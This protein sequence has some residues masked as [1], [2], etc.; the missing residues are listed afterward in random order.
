MKLIILDRDGVINEDSDEYI[1]SVDEWVPI[2]GSLEAIAR[3]NQAGYHV[4]VATN[5]S[6]IARGYYDL[7][8]LNAMH[9]KM[10]KLLA[11]VGGHV[12]GILFCPHA[13]ED[14]CDCRKPK[15]GMFE[16][17]ARRWGISLKGVP[18]VG[19]SRRD[20]EAA[21]SMGATPILVKTGKGKRTM[22]DLSGLGNVEIYNDL[23]HVVGGLVD[24]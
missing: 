1:K 9:Q 21:V 17:I 15:T 22:S 16:D 18:I 7:T 3:L 10:H 12:D 23:A 4:V 8:N 2:P 14:T 13:P 11:K 19:D 24:A 6:G 5:Q 20:L